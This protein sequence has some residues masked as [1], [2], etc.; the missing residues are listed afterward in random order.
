MK[1]PTRYQVIYIDGLTKTEHKNSVRYDY[2]TQAHEA[3]LETI[4]NVRAAF[5][6]SL[7]EYRVE[8]VR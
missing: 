1:Q 4:E 7:I 2:A 5:P 3:A 8:P 6:K